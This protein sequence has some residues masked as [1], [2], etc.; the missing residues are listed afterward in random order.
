MSVILMAKAWKASVDNAARKLVLMKLAD[1]ADDDGFCWPSYKHLAEQ[2]EMSR[3]TVMRHVEDLMLTGFVKKTVRKG[4]IHFNKSNMF[5]LTIEKG[6][7]RNLSAA[8]ELAKEEK[9]R[10]KYALPSDNLSPVDLVTD[11]HSTSATG[12]PDLVTETTQ[13]SDTGSPRTIIEPPIEPSI[14]PIKPK[15]TKK[16]SYIRD[17]F[18]AYP[19]HRRGGTDAQLWQV[20]KKHKLTELDAQACLNWLCAAANA[21]P[22][23]WSFHATEA[24]GQYVP[25]LTRFVNERRWLTPVP[26]ASNQSRQAPDFHSGDTSWANDLGDL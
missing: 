24:T 21:C 15:R 13:P 3:R 2:C 1:N 12:S 23:Q 20:W 22:E 17:L 6:D 25:G 4:G 18:L 8:R 14:D 26:T 19:V 16:P 5:E 10:A 11:D 9:E 7:I